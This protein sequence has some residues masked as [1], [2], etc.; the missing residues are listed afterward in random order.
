MAEFLRLRSVEHD[1]AEEDSMKGVGCIV[2]SSHVG[3][4]DGG[5]FRSLELLVLVLGRLILRLKM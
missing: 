2:Q 5:A 4:D 1:F 3:T